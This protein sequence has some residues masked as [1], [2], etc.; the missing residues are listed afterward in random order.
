MPVNMK[1]GDKK[2]AK[3]TCVTHLGLDPPRIKV[4]KQTLHHSLLLLHIWLCPILGA[5]LLR[6]TPLASDLVVLLA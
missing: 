1:L 3:I 5:I 6:T 4:L 2:K